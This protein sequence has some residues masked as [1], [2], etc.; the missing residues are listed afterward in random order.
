MSVFKKA[1]TLPPGD[2][3]AIPLGTAPKGFKG[4]IQSIDASCCVRKALHPT[5]LEKRLTE[6]GFVTGSVVEIKHEGL[7]N[8]DPIAVKINSTTV[9]LRRSEA[10]AILVKPMPA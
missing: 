8:H 6:I 5:E 4:R 3:Q 2:G 7:F 1:P 9:A 10:N